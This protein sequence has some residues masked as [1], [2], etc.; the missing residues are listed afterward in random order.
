LD[1]DD[2][3]I[4]GGFGDHIP[5]DE[6]EEDGPH[7]P[8]EPEEE[9][10]PAIAEGFGVPVDTDTIAKL[11]IDGV[12]FEVEQQLDAKAAVSLADE[13]DEPPSK[14]PL[15]PPAE[16]PQ[17][18]LPQEAPPPKFNAVW[19][20]I[21][22][23]MVSIRN[24]ANLFESIQA[25]HQVHRD[26]SI[27]L[28]LVCS[29]LD[30][31]PY[32]TLEWIHWDDA[33]EYKGRSLTIRHGHIVFKPVGPGRKNVLDYKPKYLDGKLA[34]LIPDIGAKMIRYAGA[35]AT[36]VPEHV[37]KWVDYLRSWRNIAVRV[38]DPDDDDDRGAEPQFCCICNKTTYYVCPLCKFTKG[39]SLTKP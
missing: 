5:D 24:V 35:H 25:L 20:F 34:L 30:E 11:D 15:P 8:P 10:G 27:S 33:A 12:N 7:G 1:H 19:P 3:E 23:W 22:K 39:F 14:P 9:E 2:R 26:K 18:E 31:E 32:S 21:E 28:A 37:L 29:G 4:L 36:D 16:L 38:V 6:N 17:V 13:S